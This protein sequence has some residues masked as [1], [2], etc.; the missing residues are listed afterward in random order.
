[1][2][3]KKIIFILLIFVAAFLGGCGA[4][5]NQPAAEQINGDQ[6]N[7]NSTVLCQ[8]VEVNDFDEVSILVQNYLDEKK[9]NH[10][11]S[12]LN[13]ETE[14][15]SLKSWLETM[16]CVSEIILHEGI[17]LS[18]PPQKALTVKFLSK[19]KEIKVSISVILDQSLKAKLFLTDSDK[20]SAQ[21]FTLEEVAKHNTEGDCWTVVNNKVYNITEYIPSH[22]AGKS[23]LQG[24]GQ[25]ATQLFTDKHSKK[26]NNKLNDYL[27][28][29]LK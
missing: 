16:S 23:I 13:Y 1:M 24:C 26:T 8:Q 14:I 4:K 25:D 7:E 21:V 20:N 11:D 3:P 28:G 29:N 9:K 5:I 15:N 17:L 2:K 12:D 22:P 10:I 27:I 6:G 19:E 18:N